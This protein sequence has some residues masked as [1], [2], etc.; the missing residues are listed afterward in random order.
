MKVMKV[1][2]SG[3]K[4]QC[5]SVTVWC[6]VLLVLKLGFEIVVGLKMEKNLLLDLCGL[7]L[8]LLSS[9]LLAFFFFSFQFWSSCFS[10][11]RIAP[12]V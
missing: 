4:K 5:L 11:F 12:A 10:F 7:F 2:T 8:L 9:S 6:R 3:R 1:R